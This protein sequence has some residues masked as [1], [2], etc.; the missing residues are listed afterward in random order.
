MSLIVF[1]EINDVYEFK[2]FNDNL[3]IIS[4]FHRPLFGASSSCVVTS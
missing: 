2:N 3:Y 1:T 4:L